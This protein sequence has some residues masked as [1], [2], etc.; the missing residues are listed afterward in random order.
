MKKEHKMYAL[1]KKN[2]EKDQKLQ[3]FFKN[4]TKDLKKLE[5]S[6]KRMKKDIEQDLITKIFKDEEEEVKVHDHELS[7]KEFNVRL[8]ARKEA[9][10]LLSKIGGF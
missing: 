10:N 5:P 1:T 2:T 7:R 3:E 8:E 4:T 6:A 9:C